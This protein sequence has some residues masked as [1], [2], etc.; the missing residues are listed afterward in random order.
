MKK[1]VLEF[2]RR[3]LI[4]CGIGPVV[5]AVVYLILQRSSNVQLLTVSEVCTGIFSL[6]ALAFSAGGLNALY[7][8]E[9]LPL[10]PAILIHGGVLYVSYL[11]TFLVNG[12]LDTGA[13]PVLV[14]SVIF[15]IGYLVIWAIIYAI[16]K[17]RTA[18]INEM[19]QKKQRA[20]G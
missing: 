17:K 3:G 9:R 19:L 1:F 18:R 7:Q 2:L 11:G 6:T 12:W 13:T 15:V 5:L 14:F 20:E 16:I 10:M 4:A 8:L